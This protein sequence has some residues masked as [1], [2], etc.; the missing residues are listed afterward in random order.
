MK[1][2]GVAREY[3]LELVETAFANITS[4]G[5]DF[6][7]Q[8]SINLS[9]LPPELFEAF[10]NARLANFTDTFRGCGSSGAEADDLT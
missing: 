10:T 4:E 8:S 3:D 9:S 5:F 1:E 2:R 6:A 7:L